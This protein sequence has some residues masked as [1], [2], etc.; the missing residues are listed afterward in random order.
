MAYGSADT[1]AAA[2]TVRISIGCARAVRYYEFAA[3][4]WYTTRSGPV[5][6]VALAA[7]CYN[8][9]LCINVASLATL[10]KPEAVHAVGLLRV[11]VYS[12]DVL[13]GLPV[14]TRP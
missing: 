1:G 7:S 4:A 11:Y 9:D 3:P 12:H 5:F 6:V 13:A 10:P 8:N 14:A 2:A